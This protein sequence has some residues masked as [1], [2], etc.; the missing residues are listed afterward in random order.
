MEPMLI[1]GLSLLAVTV[2]LIVIELFVPSGGVIAVAAG[3][4]GIAG[5][6][7]LFRMDENPVLWGSLGIILLLVL[8]PA[9][10]ALWVKLLPTT[11]WGR[12]LLGERPEEER[13]A[14]IDRESDARDELHALVGERGVAVTPLMPVGMVDLEAGRHE[15]LAEGVA[16]ER[17]QAVRVT[18]VTGT[19]LRVRPA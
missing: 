3:I 1:W 2:V 5:V 6:V 13:R 4:V 14:V 12:A 7:C 17:G 15:A 11:P 10:F 19:Q 8:F 9:S 16:I 18:G